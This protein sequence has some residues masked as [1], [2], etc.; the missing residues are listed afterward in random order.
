MRQFSS[1]SHLFEEGGG[2]CAFEC[3]ICGEAT[4]ATS[5]AEVHRHTT[6]R[7]DGLGILQYSQIFHSGQWY[8]GSLYKCFLCDDFLDTSNDRL[9]RHL[10]GVDFKISW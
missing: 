1:F 4:S 10:Q 6:S 9:R 3:E 7:H 8:E 5:A 2:G